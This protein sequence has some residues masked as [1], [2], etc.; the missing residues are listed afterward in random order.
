MAAQLPFLQWP[1]GL[2]V[3]G[4]YGGPLGDLRLAFFINSSLVL[5]QLQM[6]LDTQLYLASACAETINLLNV[7]KTYHIFGNS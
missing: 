5:W 7:N 3:G 2:G 6:R 4:S 1:W